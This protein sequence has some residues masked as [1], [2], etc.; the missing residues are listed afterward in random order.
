MSDKLEY[1]ALGF[2][3]GATAVGLAMLYMVGHL[4]WQCVP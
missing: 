1:F 2:I 3:V 4:F